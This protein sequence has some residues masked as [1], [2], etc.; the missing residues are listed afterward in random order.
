[1]I[2]NAVICAFIACYAACS[3][4]LDRTHRANATSGS[5]AYSSVGHFYHD[6]Y[7]FRSSLAA[8]GPYLMVRHVFAAAAV[9]RAR[10]REQT[11]VVHYE[12]HI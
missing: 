12:S 3:V 7:V 10:R 5:D 6:T 4:G 1:M 11:P 8:R 9:R 2:H